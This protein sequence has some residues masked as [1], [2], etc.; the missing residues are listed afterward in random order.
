M[1]AQVAVSFYLRAVTRCAE[2]LVDFDQFMADFAVPTE[3]GQ[4]LTLLSVEYL[5]GD[6]S[7]DDEIAEFLDV[8]DARL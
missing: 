8:V 4:D 6:T 3:V 5:R 1:G 7:F 2:D